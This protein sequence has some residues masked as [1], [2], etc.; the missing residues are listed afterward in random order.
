MGQREEPGTKFQVALACN[1]C[2]ADYWTDRGQA[3]DCPECGMQ[4][5]EAHGS[6]RGG[7]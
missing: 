6:S 2:G 7:A 5:F 4:D 1:N 3:N